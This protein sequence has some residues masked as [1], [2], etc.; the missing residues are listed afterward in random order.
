MDTFKNHARRQNYVL[1][2]TFQLTLFMNVR[3]MPENVPL[4]QNNLTNLTDV[5]KLKFILGTQ[6]IET[7]LAAP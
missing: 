5:E 6:L 4:N 7:H 1:F 3:V 2:F